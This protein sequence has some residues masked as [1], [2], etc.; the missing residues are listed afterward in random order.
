M[1]KFSTA[2]SFLTFSNRWSDGVM[3]VRITTPLS[4]EEGGLDKLSAARQ[5]FVSFYQT[6]YYSVVKDIVTYK[7]SRIPVSEVD[8]VTT[9][10]GK[11]FASRVYV[12]S[13]VSECGF[14]RI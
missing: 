4:E 2:W 10:V 11:A 13:T 5:D 8:A 14:T 3:E 9:A 7:P 12:N 6:I 1:V